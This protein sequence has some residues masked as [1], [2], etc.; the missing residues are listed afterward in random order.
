MTQTK[1]FYLDTPSE[2]TL[3]VENPNNTAQLL[4]Y[5]NALINDTSNE[6]NKKILKKLVQSIQKPGLRGIQIEAI[7]NLANFVSQG[8]Y[9]GLVKVP[10][11]G[12]KSRLFGEIISALLLKTIIFVPRILLLGQTKKELMTSGVPCEDIHCIGGGRAKDTS[13]KAF[14]KAIKQISKNNSGVILCTYQSFNSIFQSGNQE[15]VDFLFE[16]IDLIVRDEAHRSLGDITKDNINQILN[17]DMTEDLINPDEEED[18]EIYE[19]MTLEEELQKEAGKKIISKEESKTGKKLHLLFT[20]TPSLLL[21]DI[22]REY[23]SI[24]E[25]NIE[26]AVKEGIVTFPRHVSVG[27][28]YVNTNEENITGSYIETELSDRFVDENGIP[29]YKKIV[30][31]YLKEKAKQPNGYLPGVGFCSTIDYANKMREYCKENGIKA[32]TVTSADQE[33]KTEEQLE[34]LKTKVNSGEIELIITVAK[35]AEGFDLPTLRCTLMFGPIYSPAKR[36]QGT[37][38]TM[39]ILSDE[40]K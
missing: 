15:L 40:F 33:Y 3:I 6:Y 23:E 4:D 17:G 37:G 34:E 39:R 38:R 8:K 29:I 28:A 9:E 25:V 1:E 18:W 22:R 2:G 13:T 10:T 27:V 35:V 7:K 16:N 11:G 5:F 32:V 19:D 24:I 20:A 30:S 14:K 26:R 31:T 12:G 21:K 36:I